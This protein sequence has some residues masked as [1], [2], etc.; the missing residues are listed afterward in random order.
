M[1]RIIGFIG[2][3]LVFYYIF[4]IPQSQKSQSPQEAS[5]A[6]DSDNA[7]LSVDESEAHTP[8][9]ANENTSIPPRIKPKYALTKE[10]VSKRVKTLTD[11]IISTYSF[12]AEEIED[13]TSQLS[14]AVSV[15]KRLL[16]RDERNEI[17]KNVMGEKRFTEYQNVERDIEIHEQEK[18][19]EDAV[20]IVAKRASL[21]DEQAQN[22]K[23]TLRSV[24]GTLAPQREV[25]R[26]KMREAMSQ[27]FDGPAGKESLKENYDFIQQ[28]E[29]D[30]K[31]QR[32]DLVTSKLKE[33][34]PDEKVK[35]V[36]EELRED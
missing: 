2:L 14:Q 3:V 28:A 25:I 29:S 20:I 32:L 17:L 10:G 35:S 33:F 4:F 34:L 27:H 7:V 8:L 31:I 22:L 21:T 30:L 9:G 19:L 6:V 15:K 13:I 26:E 16:F 11:E 12:S 24:R 23:T 1:V 36:I 18:E 5:S